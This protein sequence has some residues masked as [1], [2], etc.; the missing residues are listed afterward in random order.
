MVECV[1]LYFFRCWVSSRDRKATAHDEYYVG[2]PWL[3]SV[4]LV[5]PFGIFRKTVKILFTLLVCVNNVVVVVVFVKVALW[6]EL[7]GRHF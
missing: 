4:C 3:G 1:H 7:R 6:R 5:K 2:R